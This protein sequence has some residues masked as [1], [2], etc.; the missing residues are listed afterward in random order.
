MCSR[1]AYTR[2]RAEN[3]YQKRIMRAPWRDNGKIEEIW[4][5]FRCLQIDQNFP[6]AAKEEALLNQLLYYQRLGY[7]I[8]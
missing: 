8:H 2:A 6:E 1:F 7:V 4:V 5:H 3:I